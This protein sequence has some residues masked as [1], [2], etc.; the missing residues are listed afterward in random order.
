[1]ATACWDF[2]VSKRTLPQAAPVLHFSSLQGANSEFHPQ[3]IHISLWM[4]WGQFRHLAKP[5]A[6]ARFR[7]LLI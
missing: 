4:R 1:M 3:I 5:G 7:T 2:I 6:A